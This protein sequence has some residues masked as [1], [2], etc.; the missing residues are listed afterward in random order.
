LS[1]SCLLLFVYSCE[2]IDK[3]YD[4]YTV[5][6]ETEHEISIDAYVALYYSDEKEKME[7][8]EIKNILLKIISIQHPRLL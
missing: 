1:L 7:K 5:L 8:W 2:I 4:I 6:N 3:D